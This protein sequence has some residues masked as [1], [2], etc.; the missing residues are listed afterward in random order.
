MEIALLI[1]PGPVLTEADFARIP[2]AARVAK[3]SQDE[4][5]ASAILEKLAAADDAA[6]QPARRKSGAQMRKG[7]SV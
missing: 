5:V 7:A 2:D 1:K 3:V 6:Q 4:F